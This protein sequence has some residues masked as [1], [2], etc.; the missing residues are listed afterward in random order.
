M[1][2]KNTELKREQ[3]EKALK[4]FLDDIEDVYKKHKRQLGAQLATSPQGIYPQLTVFPY[5]PKP[6]VTRQSD[7]SNKETKA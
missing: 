6:E 2:S 7:T 4:A 5:E 3:D 1:A